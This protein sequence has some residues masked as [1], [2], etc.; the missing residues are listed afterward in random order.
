M[1]NKSAL[2][3]EAASFCGLYLPPLKANG[4]TKR[5]TTTFRLIAFG[6]CKAFEI[7][8]TIVLDIIPF[9]LIPMCNSN[10]VG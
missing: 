1:S 2:V 3:G 8:P 7:D 6:G 10:F 9:A 4:R 5:P